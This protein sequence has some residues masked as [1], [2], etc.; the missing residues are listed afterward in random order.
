[1]I[2]TPPS[3]AETKTVFRYKC[4]CG[5][6]EFLLL[7]AATARCARCLAAHRKSAGGVIDFLQQKTEQNEYFD[8][9]YLAG[10]SHKRHEHSEESAP[11]YSETQGAESYLETCGFDLQEPL[12]N[13]SILEVACGSGRLT[14]ELLQNT[15]IRNCTFHAFD[16]SPHGPELLAR[17]EPS[18]RSSNRLETSVQDAQAMVFAD[19]AFDVVLGRSVL[20]HFND[21]EA[22][23]RD[24][25][26][27]LKSG[28]VATFGEPFAVGYGLA[29]AVFRMAQKQVG[30][31]HPALEDFCHDIAYRI[32]SRREQL[33]PLVDKHLFF[34]STLQSA[35]Q[36]AGF[37]SV[38]FVSL[39]PYE[40]Y[41]DEFIDDLLAERRIS[42]AR[43]AE[44]AKTMYREIVDVFAADTLV[45]SMGAFVQIVLRA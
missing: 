32:Q 5:A 31:D 20:H 3:V 43:L 10:H 35:A 41:R 7:D 4:R 17:F 25:R 38:E 1:V 37:S 6:D 16:A 27:I 28:G 23:L 15:R 26:R 11:D 21:P 30:T 36:Q 42:D 44:A 39:Y 45:H 12:D 24:C 40:Y 8:A 33:T 19:A 9:L 18:I 13:L 22:F 29:A 34:P 2:P 14:A